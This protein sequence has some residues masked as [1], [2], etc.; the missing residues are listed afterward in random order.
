MKDTK[1][2]NRLT[3]VVGN[4]VVPILI[5]ICIALLIR[6]FVFQFARVNG[7][8]MQP[9]LI[10]Q[11][12]VALIKVAPIH[13]NSV[14]IFDA[15]GE[16]PNATTHVNYVKRVIGLPGDTVESKQGNLYVN[17]KQIDQ[18]YIGSSQRRAT[19]NWNLRT[20]GREYDWRTQ[21]ITVPRG[22][23][24]VL[25]DHRS[26]SNDSRYWGFVDQDKV[27]GVVKVPFW[28]G[29]KTSRANINHGN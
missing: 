2:G 14:I 25:G 13:H 11:E 29:T 1:W 26:V 22:H 5:G 28:I 27:A 19:G 20:L 8:S 23:Y 6:A 17:G 4:V 24:F 12:R 3:K 18:S 16:D 7:P 15:K 21:S 9:N 10:D